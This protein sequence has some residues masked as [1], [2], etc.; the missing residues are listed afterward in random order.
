MNEKLIAAKIGISVIA[1]ALT[2]FLGWK[3]VLML[4]LAFL[5]AIDY[6]SGTLAAKKNG[7]WSS[8][9]ARQGLFHKG[10]TIIMVLVALFMDVIFTV[11]FP[12]IP[13]IGGGIEN[14]GIFLPLV[15]VWY[16]ITEMG[17]IMENSAKMGAKVPKWFQKAVEKVGESIDRTGEAQ[18]K[19]EEHDDT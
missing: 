7:T 12:H 19:E 6:I 1:A 15:S 2:D 13:V 11:A 8:T 16:I 3:G 5:M 17:S 9:I 14:P 18:T 10:G 4:V